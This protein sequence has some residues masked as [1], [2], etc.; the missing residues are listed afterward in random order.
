MKLDIIHFKKTGAVSLEKKFKTGGQ[1]NQR[2]RN[3][4]MGRG[5]VKK[6]QQC[7]ERIRILRRRK[8]R[9]TSVY[10]RRKG[11]EGGTRKSKDS[12][13]GV[14][15][16]E[17]RPRQDHR[18]KEKRKELKKEKFNTREG[19]AGKWSIITERIMHRGKNENS[20]SHGPQGGK[21]GMKKLGRKG[22]CPFKDGS[23]KTGRCDRMA[24]SLVTSISFSNIGN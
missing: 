1:S 10:H 12:S 18:G 7:G 6:E 22:G 5:W 3:T 9:M 4:S 2:T 17:K 24:G 16:G 14:W 15:K 13:N 21:K 19:E 11:W 8:D 23:N 20:L